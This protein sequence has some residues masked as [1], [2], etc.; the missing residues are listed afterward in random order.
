MHCAR[1]PVLSASPLHGGKKDLYLSAILWESKQAR[2]LSNF[3]LG[4]FTIQVFFR[5]FY[6]HNLETEKS[7]AMATLAARYCRKA[8]QLLF[9]Q[10]FEM[11]K[12]HR[13][14]S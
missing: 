2:S 6:I 1:C 5:T 11:Q 7:I 9:M 13:N 4:H 8:N 12:I 3:V 10:G 14:I